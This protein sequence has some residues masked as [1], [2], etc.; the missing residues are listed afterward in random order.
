M[1]NNFIFK[2][3]VILL[4]NRLKYSTNFRKRG[5][6]T[7]EQKVAVIQIA[8]MLTTELKLTRSYKIFFSQ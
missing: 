8:D 1:S 7:R 3:K 4:H 5:I 6:R 2:Q